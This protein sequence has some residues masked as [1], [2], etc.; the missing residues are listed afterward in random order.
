MLFQIRWHLTAK[1]N[2][3][4]YSYLKGKEIHVGTMVKEALFFVSQSFYWLKF[5]TA[6]SSNQSSEIYYSRTKHKTKYTYLLY[7][8]DKGI[9]KC[10]NDWGHSLLRDRKVNFIILK[11]L[12]SS[13]YSISLHQKTK[14]LVEIYAKA[15]TSYTPVW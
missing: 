4:V 11:T 12:M 9:Q 7:K 8:D 13:R 10:L 2:I 6:V 3:Q 15:M 5:S 1:L 14:T